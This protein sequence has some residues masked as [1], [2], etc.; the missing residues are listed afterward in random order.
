MVTSP[1]FVGIGGKSPPTRLA[2]QGTQ[3]P[4]LA[5]GHAGQIGGHILHGS[6]IGSGRRGWRRYR[7]YGVYGNWSR[8][9][10]LFGGRGFLLR[11]AKSEKKQRQQPQN[12][13][14][15]GKE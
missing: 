3:L 15:H 5:D 14:T 1:A 8:G 13:V 7:G 6:R 10:L 9:L 12:R 11:A 2:G 4:L